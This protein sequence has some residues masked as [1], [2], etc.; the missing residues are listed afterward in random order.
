MAEPSPPFVGGVDG[1][2]SSFLNG[3]RRLAG[4]MVVGTRRVFV[5]VHPS[6]AGHPCRSCLIYNDDDDM[7]VVVIVIVVRCPTCGLAPT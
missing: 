1:H 7:I 4:L 2:S 5:V 6:F 3:G